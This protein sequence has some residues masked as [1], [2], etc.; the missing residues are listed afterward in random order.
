MKGAAVIT[1]L[2]YI[3]RAASHNPVGARR[4]IAAP[5][6]RRCSTPPY[7]TLTIVLQYLIFPLI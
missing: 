5:R 4:Q 6:A 7:H 1:I 3:K 2:L